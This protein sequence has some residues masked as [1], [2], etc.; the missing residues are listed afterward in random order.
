MGNFDKLSVSFSDASVEMD[1]SAMPELL[2]HGIIGYP[3]IEELWACIYMGFQTILV[4]ING[5]N[6]KNPPFFTKI[7]N[8]GGL[9][10]YGSWSFT[11]GYDSKRSDSTKAFKNGNTYDQGILDLDYDSDFK[12][13]EKWN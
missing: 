12:T 8:L 4:E 13:D 6:V 10:R 9:I 3:T 1:F 2:S 7:I 11:S 5:R